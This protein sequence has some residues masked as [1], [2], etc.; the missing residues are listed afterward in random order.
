MSGGRSGYHR[1]WSGEFGDAV[2]I[3]APFDFDLATD[4]LARY[5]A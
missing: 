2:P 3:P 4:G 1:K 5:P